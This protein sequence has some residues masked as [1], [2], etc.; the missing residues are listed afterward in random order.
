MKKID[1]LFILIPVLNNMKGNL[2]MNLSARLST[3]V[4]HFTLLTLLTLHILILKCLSGKYGRIR[5]RS[6]ATGPTCRQHFAPPTPSS[7]RVFNCILLIIRS[8]NRFETPS[9]RKEEET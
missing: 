2:E 3:S 5:F 6:R 9:Q 8:R 1:E 4:S 7:H